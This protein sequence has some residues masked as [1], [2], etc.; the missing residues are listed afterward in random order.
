MEILEI[1][2]ILQEKVESS[3]NIPLINRALI[4]KEDLIASI[5]DIRLRLPD[6]LKQARWVKDERKRILADAQ[7]EADSIVKQGEEK[8]AQLVNENAITKR[9]YE[10]AN[11]IIASAQKSSRELRLGARQ[12]I[13]KILADS[14]SSLAKSQE[15]IRAMRVEMRQDSGSNRGAIETKAS[16]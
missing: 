15:T 10:Q 2:D 16:E 9:A 7:A 6:D 13:D 5:E 11:N 12:Y 3:K 8:A 4:D 1:I 14:E